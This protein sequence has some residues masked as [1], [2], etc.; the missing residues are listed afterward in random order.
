MGYIILPNRALFIFLMIPGIFLPWIIGHNT[1]YTIAINISW[2]FSIFPLVPPWKL[3]KKS[4][5]NKLKF[6]EAS[7]NQKRSICWKFKLSISLGTQKSAKTPPAVGKMIRPFYN[8][9]KKKSKKFFLTKLKIMTL[10]I[11][12]K[13]KNTILEMA[14][15][16]L[17]LSRL[18]HETSK[19]WKRIAAYELET[20][21]KFDHLKNWVPDCS[22]QGR[23]SAKS[24]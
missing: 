20:T 9:L 7:R 1:R 17:I 19:S 4:C 12:P 5:L 8:E 23:I 10:I 6:W 21:S 11:S 14:L 2:F 24:F 15:K 13:R 22:A 16:S 3:W 18:G